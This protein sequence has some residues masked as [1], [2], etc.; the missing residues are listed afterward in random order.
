MIINLYQ[1]MKIHSNNILTLLLI[2]LLL[3]TTVALFTSSMLK[4]KAKSNIKSSS[5][6]DGPTITTSCNRLDLSKHYNY[7][8]IVASG[9]LTVGKNNSALA[10]IFYGKQDVT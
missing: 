3:S 2:S 6:Q 9:Y 4:R 7:S 1:L 10:Y 8:G 5:N